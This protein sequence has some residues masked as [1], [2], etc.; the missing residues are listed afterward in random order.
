MGQ[1]SVASGL[2]QVTKSDLVQALAGEAKP[3]AQTNS[4]SAAAQRIERADVARL[5][6]VIEYYLLGAM[7]NLQTNLPMSFDALA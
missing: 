6:V 7:P 1:D 2:T 3:A 5:L 4:T